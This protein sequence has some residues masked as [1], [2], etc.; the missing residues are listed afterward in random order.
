MHF[1]WYEV[2][3]A[4]HFWSSKQ[5]GQSIQ[6]GVLALV[7]NVGASFHGDDV[8]V[9]DNVDDNDDVDDV[10]FGDYVEDV[11]VGDDTGDA[12]LKQNPNKIFVSEKF[13]SGGVRS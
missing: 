10:D 2:R 12:Q 6:S 8:D 13:W 4:S 5:N 7:G 9:G 3:F 1:R 11:D